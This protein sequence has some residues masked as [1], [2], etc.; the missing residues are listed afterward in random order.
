M[1]VRGRRRLMDVASILN[2]DTTKPASGV[3]ALHVGGAIDASTTVELE[4]HLDRCVSE[5]P[6][7]LIVDMSE[8]IYISS[9]GWGLIVK[10]MQKLAE[11]KGKLALSGL[12]SPIFKIFC[13]LGFEPLIPY[14]VSIDT[15]I[16]R[17][18]A[19]SQ[20]EG[21]EEATVNADI[22]VPVEV[23]PEP[24]TESL[25][26]EQVTM[27]SLPPEEPE[28]EDETK[29][30]TIDF[31]KKKDIREG[32]DKKIKKMGWAEYGKKLSKRNKDSKRRKK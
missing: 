22:L 7:H 13:D 23:E 14:Y 31:S 1:P 24:E 17:M 20:E 10:C 25:K 27:K 16:Q 28:E 19:A 32:K 2:F 15:A 29:I 11:T 9:S 5:E 3:I 6:E 18:D 26:I 8:V 21:A 30:V 12:P 4:N